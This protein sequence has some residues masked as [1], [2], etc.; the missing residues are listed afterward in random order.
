MQMLLWDIYEISSKEA[1]LHGVML[2]GRIR[3]FALENKINLLAE[4]TEDIDNG[5]RFAVLAGASAEN[6]E[7]YIQNIIPDAQIVLALESIKNPV[8]SK[9]NVNKEERYILE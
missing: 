5:V 1:S 2:R 8:L 9:L 7:P 4:N 3:K 6:I